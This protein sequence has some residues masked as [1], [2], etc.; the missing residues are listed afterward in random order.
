M[1]L[2]YWLAGAAFAASLAGFTAA[3]AAYTVLGAET[4]SGFVASL[5][6]GFSYTVASDGEG[7]FD[8]FGAGFDTT[9]GLNFSAVG[10]T[11]T[12]ASDS[13]W[14]SLGNQTWVLPATIPGC[15]NE[16]EP[17]CEPVGHFT[18]TTDWNAGAIGTFV[19]LDPS[20]GVSD[21]I[22]TFND[23]NGGELLFYSDPSLAAT[24]EPAAWALMLAGFAG[25]GGA[26][27]T[28]RRLATA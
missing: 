15:G 22:K 20:G 4:A 11:W 17:A 2:K 14:T 26:L 12:Q 18:S 5:F 21:V 19:I 16:N 7:S 10:F 1:T 8:P 28:R 3:N 9:D 25:L 13:S 24:P 23:A 27:R 6:P